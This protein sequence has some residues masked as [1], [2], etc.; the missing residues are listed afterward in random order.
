M[1]FHFNGIHN[2]ILMNVRHI[3]VGL[4]L[5]IAFQFLFSAYIANRSRSSHNLRT[6]DRIIATRTGL[7]DLET[8]ETSTY[9]HENLSTL[10]KWR[11]PLMTENQWTA[12]QS[13][14][15]AYGPIEQLNKSEIER[16]PESMT[17]A[18][19]ANSEYSI[20]S[21]GWPLRCLFFSSIR[22]A[23]PSSK[24]IVEYSCDIST[25]KLILPL[26]PLWSGLLINIL[27]IMGIYILAVTATSTLLSFRRRGRGLCAN[28]GYSCQPSSPICPECGSQ[29]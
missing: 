24:T 10:V 8:N 19:T 1:S 22:N 11:V 25:Y 12:L 15:S 9:T 7:F 13:S 29:P 26:K 28:C 4:C 20:T 16:V 27:L 5:A 23:D 2:R 3:A 14:L 6:T 17:I 18:D 21:C